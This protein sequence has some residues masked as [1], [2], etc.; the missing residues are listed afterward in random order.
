[1]KHHSMSAPIL[2]GTTPLSKTKKS[3]YSCSLLPYIDTRTPTPLTEDEIALNAERS[4]SAFSKDVVETNVRKMLNKLPYQIRDTVDAVVHMALSTSDNIQKDF[5]IA[6]LEVKKLHNEIRQKT[7]E[8]E[9]EK[10]KSDVYRD[11]L[12]VVEETLE[13]VNEALRD[14][15]RVSVKNLRTMQRMYSTNRMLSDTLDVLQDKKEKERMKREMMNA[16]R[17][18]SR[19]KS[20]SGMSRPTS[21]SESF[22]FGS[23]TEDSATNPGSPVAALKVESSV[24]TSKGDKGKKKSDKNDDKEDITNAQNDKLRESLLRVAREH[25]KV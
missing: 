10:R 23:D 25:Y 11:R 9:K 12:T 18:N 21:R 22:R 16:S 15:H 24:N 20:R 5:E 1:M 7:I 13:S 8:I 2:P 14:K 3:P 4:R 17:P 6:S 19:S